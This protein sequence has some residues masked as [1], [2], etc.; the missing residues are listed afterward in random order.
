MSLPSRTVDGVEVVALAGRL[1]AASAPE[2]REQIKEVIHAGIGKVLIDLS[3]VK[4]LDSSGIS[5]L[6]GAMKEASSRGG[7]IALLKVPPT[8]RSLLELTRLHRVFDSY[9]DESLACRMLRNQSAPSTPP[10]TA[11]QQA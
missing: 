3:A 1:D 2:V 10:A 6:V 5:V 7:R 4:F 8:V 9:E 11:S